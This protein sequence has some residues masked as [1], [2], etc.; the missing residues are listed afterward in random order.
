MSKN[1]CPNLN[2]PQYKALAAKVGRS[3]AHTIYSLNNGNPVSLNAD[4]TPSSIYNTLVEYH[5]ETKAIEARANMFT[6]TFR[7]MADNVNDLTISPNG[8][9]IMPDG[10]A[11]NIL[12]KGNKSNAIAKHVLRQDSL[13]VGDIMDGVINTL[14]TALPGIKIHKETFSSVSGTNHVKDRAWID[15][16]GLHINMQSMTYDTPIH[17]VSH[18]WM[19]AL[20]EHD[21]MR[22]DYLMEAAKQSIENNKV[23]YERIKSKYGD[24]TE[25][26][27]IEEYAATIAGFT[28]VEQVRKFMYRNNK[29]VTEEKSKNMFSG[30]MDIVNTIWES[31]KDMFKTLTIKNG[32]I[33]SLNELDFATAKL[34]DIF[35]AFTEDILTGAG[36]VGLGI[37]AT[38]RLMEKYYY[39]YLDESINRMY[40]KMYWLK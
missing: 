31:I 24:K 37:E 39:H 27:L 16:D 40:L 21:R 32:R 12:G 29:Y 11:I 30:L 14:K 10:Q 19:H 35:R 22:Y 6:E 23:L 2:D 18:I 15:N 8:A 5:G 38:D 13:E 25:E 26:Q 36:V 17:E 4:G 9:I 33:T 20:K 3:K 34:D 1:K 28:S 7:S